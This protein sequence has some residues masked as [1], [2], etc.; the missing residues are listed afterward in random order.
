MISTPFT[1]LVGCK[2]PIQQAVMG[3]ISGRQL[4]VA[5]ANAGAVGMMHSFGPLSLRERID[6]VE[7]RTRGVWGIGF[8]ADK[9]D[10]NREGFDI[11]IERAPIIELCWDEPKR[12]LV[13]RIHKGGALAFW[14]VGSADSARAAAEA[15]VD[16]IVAQ[17]N[18]AG[19]HLCGDTPLL[20]LLEVIVTAVDV[21]VIAAGGIASGRSMAAA[22]AAGAS[23][24]RVGTLFAASLE[25]DGSDQYRQALIDAD[26]HD[27]VITTVFGAEWPDAPHRV[28]SSCITAAEAP[29]D[30]PVGIYDDGT[31]NFDIPRFSTLAPTCYSTGPHDA[32]AMY[33]GT[34]VNAV[35]E[36]ESAAV[37]VERLAFEAETCLRSAGRL[38]A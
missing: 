36:I 20:A 29:A 24:V 32:M 15:A 18:E 10:E 6:W 33:A 37:T 1:E 30:D 21:P 35:R 26:S 5:V 4:A 7:D 38:P 27:S 34:G 12:E 14:Q 17:G 25:S 3:G 23:A 19:G 11:A 2:H 8:R 16:V 22:L 31:S 9:I 13:D 28:L